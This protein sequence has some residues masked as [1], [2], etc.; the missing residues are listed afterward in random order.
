VGIPYAQEQQRPAYIETRIGDTLFVIIDYGI[1]IGPYEAPVTVPVPPSWPPPFTR[2]R[3][4]DRPV[5]RIVAHSSGGS[6]G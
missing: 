5:R 4:P 2:H 6:P 3:L 1:T